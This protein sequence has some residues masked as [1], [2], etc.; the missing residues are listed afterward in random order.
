[1]RLLLAYCSFRQPVHPWDFPWVDQLGFG[2]YCSSKLRWDRCSLCLLLHLY[3]CKRNC[4]RDHLPR[5]SI[6][7]SN[8]AIT[9][10][11]PILSI[12]FN[13]LWMIGILR[14]TDLEISLVLSADFSFWATAFIWAPTLRTFTAS[15]FILINPSALFISV[16]MQICSERNNSCDKYLFNE[17]T[18]FWQRRGCLHS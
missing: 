9:L 5:S 8:S 17:L 1:M 12:S 7:V 10:S 11:K 18:W 2:R 6:T 14:L 13:P 3:W 16:S 4:E 15:V